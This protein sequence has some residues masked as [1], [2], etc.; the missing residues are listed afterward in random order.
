M[1]SAS[2]TASDSGQ[3]K[4]KRLI[5]GDESRMQVEDTSETVT[6]EGAALHAAPSA[7]IR[8]RIVVKSEPVADIR[9]EAVDGHCE[10]AMRIA[11][12]EQIELGNVM[13]LSITGQV[14]E[15]ARQSNLS[16]GLSPRK[17]DGRNLKNHSHLTVARHL[18]EKTLTSMLVV[19]IRGG[20]ERGICSAAL[21][22][23]LRIVK[24][25]IEERGRGYHCDEQRVNN[26]EKA[27]LKLCCE[28]I[29]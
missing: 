11:S 16:G 22:E 9:Q 23:F 28:R 13:E 15:W 21:R 27:S 1:K 7:I 10:K 6:G 18:R 4:E 25:Q 20:E 17:V 2:L 26:L 24:D 29:N 3:R 19:I 5:P 8:R 12:V 14:L